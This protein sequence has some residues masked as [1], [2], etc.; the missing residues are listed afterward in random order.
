MPAEAIQF[1]V[2]S[3]KMQFLTIAFLKSPEGGKRRGYFLH[4]HEKR[5]SEKGVKL[6]RRYEILEKGVKHTV[7]KS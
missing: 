7:T 1:M 5:L 3:I 4:Q 6:Q 2:M